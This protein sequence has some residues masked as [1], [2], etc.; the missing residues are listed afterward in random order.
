MKKILSTSFMMAAVTLISLTSCKKDKNNDTTGSADLEA[1]RSSISFDNSGSFAGG[2]SFSLS[3][4]MLCNAVQTT[5]GSIRN[6]SLRATE[7]S[8]VKSR[9]VVI[10]IL[11]DP[12]QNTDAGALTSA[13]DTPTGEFWPTISLSSTDGGTVGESYVGKTGTVK[14][15][16]LTSG[17]IEGEFSGVV[18]N[19]DETLSLTLSNG[20]FAGKF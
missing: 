18:E 7:T 13:F 5:S 10:T 20:H 12:S 4:T 3:N 1:G 16:K 2:S 11:I 15:T 6:I 14:I 8:G 19:D 9:T 17:E